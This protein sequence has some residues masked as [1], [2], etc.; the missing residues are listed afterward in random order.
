[1]AKLSKKIGL[2]LAALTAATISLSGC[3][4]DIG[5]GYASD[6]YAYNQYDCDPYSPFD[7]YY[8]CDTSYGFYNIGYGGGWYDSYWY[9]GHGYYIFD[10]GGRRYN[11][12]DNH[13]RYWGEQRHRYWRDNHRGRGDHHNG[14]RGGGHHGYDRNSNAVD[15][16]IAWPERHGGRRHEEPGHRPQP[17]PPPTG[18]SGGYRDRPH[19]DGEGRGRGHRNGEG[20]RGGNEPR[21]YDQSTWGN[22]GQ[23]GAVAPAPAVRSEPR[24]DRPG[25]F[26]GGRGEGRGGGS[27][28]P[29][30]MV[31]SADS[32]YQAPREQARPAQQS[33][34]FEAPAPRYDPPPP[35]PAPRYDPPAPSY[36]PPSTPRD[37]PGR[38]ADPQ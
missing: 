3:V 36:N 24:A 31:G 34:R 15:Q 28:P 33:Q 1:M 17:T 30:N 10:R 18:D 22:Q 2:K 5:L 26:E 37:A 13:R 29:V 12:R 23:S 21:R 16:P 6:G 4:Y 11:M 9:P 19:S 27:R 20:R 35:T 8:D 38:A 25:R 7:S 14:R 32:S